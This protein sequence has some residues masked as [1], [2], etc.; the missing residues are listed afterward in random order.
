V[1]PPRLHDD[2]VDIDESLARRLLAEQLPAYADLPLRQVPSGGTD[3]VVFRLGDELA[4]R[5]PM[6]PDAVD[7]LRKELRWLPVIAPHVSLEVPEIVAAGQPADGYP[8]PWAVVRW[9]PGQDALAGRIRSLRDTALTLAQFVGELQSI[10]AVPPRESEGFVRGGPLAERDTAFRSALAQCDGLLDIRLMQ[11]IWEDALAAPNWD[12]TPV[13]LHADL[14]PGNLLVRDG[15]VVGVLDFGVMAT[16]DPAYDVT[17]A[18]HVLDRESRALFRDRLHLDDA[19]WRRARG[20]VVSGGVIAL[21]YY[22]HTNPPMVAVARRGIAE[23]LADL[24]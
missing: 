24:N 5:M 9:L 16:G 1:A 11:T 21:P 14:L 10:T 3:N 12:G 6:R 4:V 2:Q 13:W 19:T 8:F 20:L 15:R 7:S 17:P 23:V 18:W 22:L